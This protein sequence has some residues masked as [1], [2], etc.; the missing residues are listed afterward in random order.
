MLLTWK[1][2]PE[3]RVEHFLKKCCITNALDDPEESIRKHCVII[4]L[5][6]F[7]SFFV[8]D[9]IRILLIISYILDLMEYGLRSKYTTMQ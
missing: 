4:Y 6:A 3:L 2:I 8:T 7:F 9:K 1:K 5:A